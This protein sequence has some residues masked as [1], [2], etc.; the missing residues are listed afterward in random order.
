MPEVITWIDA[1]GNEYPL[2]DQ[3]DVKVIFDREGFYMPPVDYVLETVPL[4]NQ[5]ANGTAKQEGQQVVRLDIKPREVRLELLVE[6]VDEADKWAKIRKYIKAFSPLKGEGRLEVTTPGSPTRYL[7]CRYLD[8][9][10]GKEDSE[11]TTP[12]VQRL[13][14]VL[15]AYD[16]YWYSANTI[17]LTLTQTGTQQTFFPFFPLR[18]TSFQTFAETVI[19][20]D[21]E[22]TAYPVWTVYGPAQSLKFTNVTTGQFIQVNDPG[23][24]DEGV[25]LLNSGQYLTIDTRPGNYSVIRSDGT[26]LFKYVSPDSVMWGL[27]PGDNIISLEIASA[28]SETRVDLTY[29]TK[30]LG[31]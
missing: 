9:L 10:T 28:A 8:G 26:N 5:C 2:T 20:N 17:S 6:G 15:I 14:V 31:V 19:N 12:T 29:E 13:K 18:L 7:K 23:P 27:Q 21:G 22:A 3:P 11:S 24:L 4:D 25:M 1:D 30:Y 16:P